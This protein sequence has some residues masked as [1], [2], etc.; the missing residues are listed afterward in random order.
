MPIN[1]F[2]NSVSNS[3]NKIDTALFVKK[4]YVR[5]NYIESNIEEDIDLKDQYRN[6]NLPHPT[7]IHA[8]CNKDYV[9]NL[10]NDSSIVKT[11][12]I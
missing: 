4:P 5:T 7:E 1:V 10:F 12:L 9:D 3:Q 11:M 8:A 6:K 2:G